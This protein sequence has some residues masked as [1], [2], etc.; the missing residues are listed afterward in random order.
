MLL[1]L[2]VKVGD[3]TPLIPFNE[4]DGN[5]DVNPGHCVELIEKLGTI[6]LLITLTVIVC[7]AAH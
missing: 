4:V 5:G 3:Q 2:G 7:V 1:E 6:E